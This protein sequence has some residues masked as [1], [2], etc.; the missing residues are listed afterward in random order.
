MLVWG[1]SYKGTEARRQKSECELSREA[2]EG[3]GRWE[4]ELEKH[5]GSGPCKRGGGGL[6]EDPLPLGTVLLPLLRP[7]YP[8]L[9]LNCH[10][11][12]ERGISSG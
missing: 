3:L 1:E 11:R 10:S 2:G 6:R 4:G 8:S 12:W 9:L 7:L 5:I